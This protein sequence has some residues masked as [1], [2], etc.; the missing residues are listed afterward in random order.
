MGGALVLVGSHV[1]GHFELHQLLS[2][3]A[4]AL[5]KKVDVL[6][7]LGLA[8]QLQK[9]HPQILGHRSIPPFGDVDNPD[10][11]R[12][13]PAASTAYVKKPTRPWT[14]LPEPLQTA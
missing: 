3:G 14:Q 12:R 7:E 13:W 10:K 11:N 9:S 1:L 4:Y 8:Q 6:V 2:H 5:A